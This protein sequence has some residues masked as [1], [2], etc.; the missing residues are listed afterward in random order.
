MAEA[1]RLLAEEGV[2]VRSVFVTI[3]PDRDTPEALREFA[4]LVHP[5]MIGL[6]G[7]DEQIA[8]AAREYRVY[9]ARA[10]EA[11]DPYYLMDHSTF[12]Y[13]M[14]PDVGFLDFFR[15][16]TPPE[17]MAERVSCYVDALS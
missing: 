2:D 12:T 1:Q 4:A 3:D 5:E 7:S 9:Y 11:D 14:H 17:D 8:D 10:G 6:T 15:H 13:L 16:G